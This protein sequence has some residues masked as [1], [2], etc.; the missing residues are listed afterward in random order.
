MKLAEALSL[1]KSLDGKVGQ[2]ADMLHKAAW[3]YHGA[4]AEGA[5]SF[6]D[7]YLELTMALGELQDLIER[8]NLTNVRTTLVVGGA[9]MTVTQALARRDI[10]GRHIGALRQ[11]MQSMLNAVNPSGSRGWFSHG[12]DVPRMVVMA[13]PVK[14]LEQ[15][16]DALVAQH[17]ALDGAIQA[18][19]WE[20]ELL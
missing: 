3:Q 19:G 20:T 5:P 17:R 10:L 2:I 9:S 6:D 11:A 14:D 16:V 8:I 1:R 4:T 18:K 12:E 15:R 13:M 7:T